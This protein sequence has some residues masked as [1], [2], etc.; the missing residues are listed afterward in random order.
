[1]FRSCFKDVSRKCARCFKEVLCCMSATRVEGGL[2]MV[3]A[4][5]YPGS[6]TAYVC[7]TTT[8]LGCAASYPGAVMV[9]LGS[10]TA[11][12]SVLLLIWL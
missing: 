2:V 7:S 5:A 11:Y 3:G 1:M 12:L 4:T 6:G 9:Y 8:Y 10:V